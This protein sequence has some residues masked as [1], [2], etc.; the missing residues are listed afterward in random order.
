MNIPDFIILSLFFMDLI[1]ILIKIEEDG[2]DFIFYTTCFL[3]YMF[4]FFHILY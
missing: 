4:V 2:M 1:L 3:S